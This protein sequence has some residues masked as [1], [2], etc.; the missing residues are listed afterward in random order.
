M[1]E[2]DDYNAEYFEELEEVQDMLQEINEEAES[3]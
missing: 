1:Y 3:H 2:I